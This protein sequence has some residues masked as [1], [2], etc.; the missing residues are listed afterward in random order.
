MTPRK[1]APVVRKGAP[2]AKKAVAAGRTRV[3]KGGAPRRDGSA[4]S[5]VDVEEQL[6]AIERDSGE[7]ELELGRGVTLH[8]SSLRKA[9]FSDV[10]VTKGALMRYYARVAPVLFQFDTAPTERVYY[11]EDDS[12]TRT[13]AVRPWKGGARCVAVA[14]TR[15]NNSRSSAAEANERE[16]VESPPAS[17]RS[18]RTRGVRA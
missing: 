11:T 3:G 8:V 15:W 7:G 10:G 5:S 9:Y 2:R 12:A 6:A 1:R 4:T 14:A 16:R 18:S 13:L 17:A